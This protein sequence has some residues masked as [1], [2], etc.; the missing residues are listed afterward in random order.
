[1]P[2]TP[3]RRYLPAATLDFLLPVYDP[4]M[5]LLG[6]RAA[7]TPL[8]KQAELQTGDVVL[9]VGCGTGTLALLIV[10]HHPDVSVIGVDPDPKAL[11]R[12]ERK[13]SRA[14]VAIQFE[15]GF[16]DGL[17]HADAFF[18]R[19]FSSMMFHHVPRN[20]RPPVL[21]EIRRVLKPGG[22]L[23]FL[24]FADDQLSRQLRDAGFSEARRLGIRRTIPRSIEY[25]QASA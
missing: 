22:R 25:H 4:L 14:G 2:V 8:V 24:D 6:Y 10:Q 20:E 5:R 17:A 1:M 16:G 19:V 7:L 9:D 13:A 18:D 12:A 15:R 3:A 23:E 11:A 21:A